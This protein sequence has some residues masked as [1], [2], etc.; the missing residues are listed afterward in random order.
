MPDYP[1]LDL[2]TVLA[3]VQKIA[4]LPPELLQEAQIVIEEQAQ[5]IH[6]IT[7]HS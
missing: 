3:N 2:Q 5:I 4:Y 7:Q 6:A 1:S